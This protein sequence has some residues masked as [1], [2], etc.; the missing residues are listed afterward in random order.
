MLDLVFAVFLPALGAAIVFDIG[1]ST[2]GTDIV[3]L[4]LAKYTSMEIGKALMVSDIL[5]VL[6]AAVRFGM[7]T[8]LYCI[9]G[10]IGKSFVVDGA[11]ENIRLR[12]VCTIM[13]ANPQPILDF[14]I[15]NMNRSATV[16]KGLRCLHPPRAQRAG[17]RTHPP[18][19]FTAA[20]LSARERPP[21]LYHHRQLQRDHR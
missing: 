13:T 20:Q 15:H 2:G 5:I 3:A 6:A 9:L 10:L 14:I 18:S 12:K 19:G 4:I 17:D 1:A 21:Q 11:I 8:G 16:E 7:G